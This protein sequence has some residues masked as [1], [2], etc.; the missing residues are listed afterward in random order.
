MSHVLINLNENRQYHGPAFCFV[1]EKLAYL[2]AYQ[3]F[4][5]VWFD[6][7]IVGKA[8]GDAAKAFP[9]FVEYVLMFPKVDEA[10]R[11][12]VGVFEKPPVLSVKRYDD[13]DHSFSGKV[14]PV[15]K[16]DLLN[17]ADSQAVNHDVKCR[18]FLV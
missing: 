18:N 15:A 13:N 5:V 1:V 12:D 7:L 3:C 16:H 9:Y 4:Q 2:V 17:I 11:Y 14:P 10:A 8:R 6:L